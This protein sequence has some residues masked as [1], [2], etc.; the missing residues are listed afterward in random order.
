MT[1]ALVF[2]GR[3]PRTGLPFLFTAQAQKEASVN[4]ALARIDALLAP[5]VE[6]EAASPPPEPTDG[7]CWII[8]PN[9]QETWAG[10]AGELAIH[11]AGAWHFV[12]PIEGMEVFDTSSGAVRR[13]LGAWHTL[14]LPMAPSGGATIDAEAR[15]A[16]SALI[17]AL[18]DAGLG[19]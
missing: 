11:T 16:I 2:T 19:T 13:W 5:G 10:H 7:E 4:E 6:G 8:A 9:P 14:S 18:R 1:T 15:A 3:S 12:T 17:S